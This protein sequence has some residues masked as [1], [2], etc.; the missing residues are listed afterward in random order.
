LNGGKGVKNATDATFETGWLDAWDPSLDASII[1]SQCF[2]KPFIA[3]T[4]APGPNENLPMNC[5]NWFEAYAFC[6]WKGGFLPTE[7]EFAYAAAG[8][9]DADGQ[10]EYPWGSTPPGTSNEYAIYGCYYSNTKC[11]SVASI[12][13]VGTASKGAGRW[14]Q[15]DMSG[16]VGELLLDWWAPYVT[17]CVDCAYVS[18]QASPVGYRALRGGTFNAGAEGLYAS[19]RGEGA[20]TDRDYYVGFRCAYPP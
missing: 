9:G 18:P 19:R 15:R 12:A 14:G 6:I 10:R 17:P 1:A 7:A 20:A 11:T 13:P 16:E 2:E 3:W 4:D 8:G 5:M